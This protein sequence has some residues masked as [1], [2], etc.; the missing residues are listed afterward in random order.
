MLDTL[1]FPV[2]EEYVRRQVRTARRAKRA[3]K[4]ARSQWRNVRWDGL[5]RED[6]P[7]T[8]DSVDDVERLC[9][10]EAPVNDDVVRLARMGIPPLLRS[11]V[12]LVCSGATG[13]WRQDKDCY[14]RML[15]KYRRHGSDEDETAAVIQIDKDL[16]RT[17]PEHD[18]YQDKQGREALR[19]V[20][21]A[22]SLRNPTIGYCQSMNFM[23]AMLL[24]V[25][26]TEEEAF[27]LMVAAVEDLLPDYFS[28]SLLGVQVDAKVFV[29]LVSVH[30]KKL[31]AHFQEI[32]ML[33]ELTATQ[34]LMCLYVGYLPADCQMRVWDL[35]FVEGVHIL[36]TVGI[37]LLNLLETE[38]LATQTMDECVRVLRSGPG[39]IYDVHKIMQSAEDVGA[40]ILTH[41]SINT[42]RRGHRRAV[43]KQQ[44]SIQAD[45]VLNELARTGEFSPDELAAMKRE[46][47]SLGSRG[48]DDDTDEDDGTD[49][50]AGERADGVDKDS[51]I[52][53]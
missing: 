3:V 13:R 30:C 1:G 47:R 45:R 29:D 37:G 14:A 34:W 48:E 38:L 15:R 51:C 18:E 25:T 9:S 32:G 46:F 31:Y 44:A 35:F 24:L 5:F 39:S 43:D 10:Q 27:W 19:R 41:D 53:F 20:L 36:F 42:M 6:T 28:S 26:L 21:V 7:I 33:L 8:A 2:D 22:Y 4:E 49:E 40:H 52:P 23:A 16:E 50:E 17:F 11:R 12:W